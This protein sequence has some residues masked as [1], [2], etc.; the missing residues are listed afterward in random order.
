MILASASRAPSPTLATRILDCFPGG[1]YALSALLRL[2]DIV[3]SDAVPTAAVE[4]RA[5]PRLLI[6]PA[7][8]ARGHSPTSSDVGDARTAPCAARG[9]TAFAPSWGCRSRRGR[10]PST[11]RTSGTS[12]TVSRLR[13]MPTTSW[14]GSAAGACAPRRGPSG[15]E[16]GVRERQ[17][18]QRR[19]AGR[20][21][22]RTACAKRRSVHDQGS[23]QSAE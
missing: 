21:D 10:S 11:R 6:N 13:W 12:S 1:A 14:R 3:E 17:R 20:H 8:V 2:M 18:S 9:P 5:Q 4:C 15:A 19:G 23:H 16:G 22:Q 7:F